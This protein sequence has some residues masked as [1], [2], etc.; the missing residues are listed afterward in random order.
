M[1]TMP[2][3]YMQAWRDKHR[4][5][6]RKYNREAY[7]KP[8]CDMNCFACPFPDCRNNRAP[9]KQERQM[10]DEAVGVNT[11][12]FQE[13]KK[14]RE[15]RMKSAYNRQRYLKMKELKAK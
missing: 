11:A 6:V 10:L 5:H 14:Q 15:K 7:H 9:T 12:A 1:G 3:E 4:E 2:K 13:Q 8:I